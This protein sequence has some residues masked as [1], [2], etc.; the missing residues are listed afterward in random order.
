MD[1]SIRLLE[2]VGGETELE[3]WADGRVKDHI[4]ERE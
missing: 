1:I 4:R 2:N 3:Q